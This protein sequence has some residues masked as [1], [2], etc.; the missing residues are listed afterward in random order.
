MPASIKRTLLLSLLIAIAMP[1][2]GQDGTPLPAT[3]RKPISGSEQA[4]AVKAAKSRAN[5]DQDAVRPYTLQDPL[6]FA[7][8]RKVRS[9]KQWPARRQE[10]L[11]MFQSEMYG[12]IPPE[13]D[14]YLETIEEGPTLAGFA[15]RRQVRMWFRPD[16]SGP[17]IDWL[18]IIPNTFA[19]ADPQSGTGAK[20]VPAILFLNFTGNHEVLPDKEILLP[21]AWMRENSDAGPHR[22]S[23]STRG[24]YNRDGYD[25]VYPIGMLCARGYA[26]VTACYCDVSP[27]P[28]PREEA[29]NGTLL[30][31]G[32][33]YTGVF[34]L[35]G[36][37][38][39]AHNDN[40]G[41][42]AAWAWALMR[43]MDMIGRD[44][45]L[46]QSRVVLTGCS[47]LGKTALLAGAYDERFP[48]VVPVQTGAGGV[49]LAKRD[50]GE[51]VATETASFRHWFCP[52]YD[53][54]ADNTDALP[55]DQHL[56]LSCVAPRALF[57]EGFNWDWFDPLGEYLAL[58][59]ASPVWKFLGTK[60]L[61]P[62]GYPDTYETS[63]IGPV[64]GYYRRSK[65]H[66]ISAL[67]W[68]LMLD[69]ADR[70]WK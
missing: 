51:T 21:D 67:D 43:G 56:L 10:I 48:L 36:P 24:R 8:G 66:G 42:I 68:K 69:F 30:Q 15:T 32:F 38:D 3:S 44:P 34:G 58:E 57:V 5:Y 13:S 65:K 12:R 49:P 35:W 62:T 25:T 19:A 40:T 7:D 59:A 29:E 4:A 33:A 23:E 22:A 1:A 70:L 17:K 31:D 41:S 2:T 39:P 37:R 50:F 54:Y 11:E 20:P 6:T 14:I 9:R 16:K 53:K 60:G 26:I 64:V 28:N 18:I 46:D 45:A 47:R 27:D 52:A 55:F 63:A 61:P